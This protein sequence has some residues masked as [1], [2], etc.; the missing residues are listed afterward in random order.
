MKSKRNIYLLIIVLFLVALLLFVWRLSSDNDQG[1]NIIPSP[2][3]TPTSEP[4]TYP[5]L[6]PSPTIVE[7]AGKGDSPEELQ[8][9]LMQKFPLYD[10]LPFEND[11]FS[12]DY[13]GPLY[14]KVFLK[15]DNSEVRK[16]VSDWIWSKGIN[17]SGH[18]ID[19]IVQP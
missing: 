3:P 10:S 5:S 8:Q 2:T 16:S 15:N 17:P 7:K 6:S 18:K 9:S 19:W 12:I 1:N 4:T 13:Y 11:L 14:L